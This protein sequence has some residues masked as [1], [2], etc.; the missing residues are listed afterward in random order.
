LSAALPRSLSACARVCFFAH[1]DPGGEVADHVLHYL[2][3]LERAGFAVVF[4]T[5]SVPDA[6]ARASLD[7]SCYAVVVRSNAGLDFGSWAAAFARYG[8]DLRGDLL[9]ANDSVYGPLADLDQAL[10]ALLSEDAD[11]YGLVE[12]CEPSPHVQSWFVLL[13]RRAYASEAFRSV[14]T[15]PFGR[16][17]KREIIDAG[18]IGL[19]R[20]L[21]RAGFRYHAMLRPCR[22]GPLWRALRF[23]PAQL[24]W[25]ELVDAAVVPFIKV[26]VLRDNPM[27]LPDI[28]DWRSV[29]D[30]AAPGLVRAIGDHLARIG[31]A[32]VSGNPAP[33]RML[34]RVAPD[35]VAFLRREFRLA[36]A[37]R[38]SAVRLNAAAF[39]A[40]RRLSSLS[41]ALKAV[42]AWGR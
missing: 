6:E 15:L 33:P 39:A 16:M 28:G 37:G 23:N 26:E 9:L 31:A 19:T 11:F 41:T 25:R 30:S 14:L 1:H 2:A 5:T 10:N 7:Q 32:A 20:A 34:G 40:R 3:Q 21:T 17:T 42:V 24:L 18:E 12:N 22:I 8:G 4:V 36:A 13:R 35:P 29:V 27:E 38:G